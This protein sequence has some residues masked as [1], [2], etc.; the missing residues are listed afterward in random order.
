M[1]FEIHGWFYARHCH[2]RYLYPKLQ[3]LPADASSDDIREAK[4]LQYKNRWMLVSIT[5]KKRILDKKPNMIDLLAEELI[6]Y[7]IENCTV[8]SLKQRVEFGVKS[9]KITDT[10][11]DNMPYF[12]EYIE[13]LRKHLL[14]CI[15]EKW[16]KM[17]VFEKDTLQALLMEKLKNTDFR[18]KAAL[19]HAQ[20]HGVEET[21]DVIDLID[22]EWSLRY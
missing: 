22:R 10:N 8:R 17:I 13:N 14:N 4:I 3:N 11:I 1:L 12:I 2:Y 5:V 16:N 21:L 7:G 15:N 20:E 18:V 6:K 19:Y 9:V